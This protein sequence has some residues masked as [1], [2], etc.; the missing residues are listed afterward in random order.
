MDSSDNAA[1]IDSK[2]EL[3]DLKFLILWDRGSSQV[4]VLQVTNANKF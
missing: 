3:L 4:V 2:V 1:Y